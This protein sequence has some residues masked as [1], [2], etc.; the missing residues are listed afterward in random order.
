MAWLELWEDTDLLYVWCR[1]LRYPPISADTSVKV[2]EL[3]LQNP[4][5]FCSGFLYPVPSSNCLLLYRQMLVF[6]TPVA[7]W[8]S[9]RPHLAVKLGW[10]WLKGIYQSLLPWWAPTCLA[11]YPLLWFQTP[12]LAILTVGCERKNWFPPGHHNSDETHT[13]SQCAG[14][15]KKQSALISLYFRAGQCSGQWWFIIQW[16]IMDEGIC[17]ATNCFCF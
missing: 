4:E 9:L 12:S 13:S 3:Y 1:Y 5:D 2:I 17:C 10:K 14:P 11:A 8:L 7:V 6:R 15:A 16:F